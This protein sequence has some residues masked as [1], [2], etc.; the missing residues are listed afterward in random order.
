MSTEDPPLGTETSGLWGVVEIMGHR[1]RAG[2]LS[3]AQLGGATMLRIEH[4]TAVD[5]TGEAPLTEF[6]AP[7]AIFAIRLCS[8]DEAVKAASW[9]WPIRTQDRLMLA[10]S[11]EDLIDDT[12][13]LEDDFDD[14]EAAE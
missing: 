13:D 3:D 8:P 4:P 12:A 7:A 11:F 2:R 1:T 5:H 9:A 14:D 10:P 6:Y